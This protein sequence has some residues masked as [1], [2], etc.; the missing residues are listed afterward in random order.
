MEFKVEG[1]SKTIGDKKILNGLDLLLKKGDVLALRGSN[2]S[3][4]NDIMMI[5][6]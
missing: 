2:G 4:D 6:Q 5:V 1:L 3:G